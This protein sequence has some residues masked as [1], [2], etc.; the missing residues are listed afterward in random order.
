MTATACAGLVA[1]AAVYINVVEH[2]ARLAC[3]TEPALAQFRPSYER[4]AVMQ[5][6]L[7]V[8]GSV[9]GLLAALL[10]ADRQLMIASLLLGG[11]VPFTLLVIRQTNGR[12]L[13]AALDARERPGGAAA[14]RWGTS[15]PPTRPRRSV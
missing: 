13:D 4:A 3:G 2:P 7:A 14:L 8:V 5:A 11:V 9:T 1:G 12:L 10:H 6:S 15:R